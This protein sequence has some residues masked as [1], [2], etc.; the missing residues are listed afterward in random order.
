MRLSSRPPT[1]SCTHFPLTPARFQLTSTNFLT[2]S[3]SPP[4]RWPAQVCSETVGLLCAVA[5][6][7]S[8]YALVIVSVVLIYLLSFSGILLNEVPVYFK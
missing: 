1:H 2:A 7:A 5:S 3:N 8:S 4:R 6:K